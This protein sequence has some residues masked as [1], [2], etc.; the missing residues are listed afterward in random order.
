MNS[1]ILFIDRYLLQPHTLIFK[2]P[3]DGIVL[4]IPKNDCHI[5]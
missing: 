5:V 2:H 4:N 3:T 1:F